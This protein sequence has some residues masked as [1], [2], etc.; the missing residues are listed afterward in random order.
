MSLYSLGDFSFVTFHNVAD[1]A[2][3][4]QIVQGE[5]ETVERKGVDGTGILR[6]GSRGK[7]FQMRSGV[8]G[9]TRAGADQT[10]DLYAQMIGK[11]RYDMVWADISYTDTHSTKYVVLDVQTIKIKRLSVKTG[12]LDLN[13]SGFWVEAIWTLL[14]VPSE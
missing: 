2:G 14:P 13:L 1:M 7:P 6:T 3:P 10:Q 4:P 11:K 5:V 8:D 12:G 9:P